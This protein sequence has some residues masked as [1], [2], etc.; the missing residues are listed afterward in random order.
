MSETKVSP[1]TNDEDAPGGEGEEK[2]VNNEILQ[3]LAPN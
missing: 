3:A 1:K 2:E